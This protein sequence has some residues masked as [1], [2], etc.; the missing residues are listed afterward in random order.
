VSDPRIEWQFTTRAGSGVDPGARIGPYEV[1]SRLGAGGMGTV[2]RVRDPLGRPLAL[3]LL[4]A[5]RPTARGRARFLREGQVTAALDHPGIVVV[6]DAGEDHGH[7]Y[8]VYELVEGRDLGQRFEELDRGA[9]LEVIGGVADALGHA[10]ARGVIHRDLKPENILID[11]AGRARVADFGLAQAIGLE[12][13]TLSGA[14]LGTPRAMAPEQVTGDRDRYG[15]PTD[16]WALGLLL[17]RALTGREAFEATGTLPE[18]ASRLIAARFPAPR[19]VASDV[20]P[21]LEQ[22]CLRAL[23]PRPEDRQP[24]GA[25]FAADLRA[26]LAGGAARGGRRVWPGAALAGVAGVGLALWLAPPGEPAASASG[27]SPAADPS[28]APPRPRSRVGA[29]PRAGPGSRADR[30]DGRRVRLLGRPPSCS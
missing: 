6:H 7:L 24:D 1:V 18:L 11:E 23:S 4:S 5:A 27:P 9:L 25:A 2:F 26:A 17:Y 22:A 29:R 16:V 21:R 19:K 15:P 14:L 28:A 13:L 20:D 8:L 30:L 12:R 10:H 3:K